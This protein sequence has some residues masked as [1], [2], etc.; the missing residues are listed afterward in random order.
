MIEVMTTYYFPNRL[1]RIMLLALE[2][3]LGKNGLT[4]LLNLSS[5]S[6]LINNYPSNTND[7]VISFEVISRLQYALEQGYG[8]QGGRGLALRAGRVFFSKGLR[9]YGPD[10]GLNDTAFRL[11]P[12]DLKL[13]DVLYSLTD[14]FNQNTNQK[15][16]LEDNEQNILWRI[17]CCPWCWG[18][19]EVEPAC[20][21]AVGMIQEALYWVS[22][23]KIYN[24]VEE[25]CIAQGD[26]SC[27]IFIERKPMI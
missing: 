5:L 20:Y 4:A 1:G 22:G 11:Q 25:T 8:P 9:E 27:I 16:V 19:Q 17:K 23:G 18:R 13:M 10:L 12:P 21:M 26:S 6:H 2:E 3:V 7:K 24:V 15:V 14:F